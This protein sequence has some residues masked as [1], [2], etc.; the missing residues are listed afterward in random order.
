[1][2][3]YVKELKMKNHLLAVAFTSLLVPGIAFSDTIFG[4]YAGG[5][6]WSTDVDGDFTFVGVGG[7]DEIDI[8]DDLDLDGDSNT[9]LYVAVEHP[10]PFVPNIKLQRSEMSSESSTSLST[11]IAFDDVVF[12][13][14]E[15]VNSTIDLSHTDATLYYEILDNWVSLD[16]G[17]TVR[18]FDGEIDISSETNPALS[19]TVDINAPIPMLY[20]KARF[21]LPF[22]GF[23]VA[24]EINTLGF[25]SDLTIK[26]AYE[27]PFRFGVE[28]GYRTFN[29]SLDD[30][31]DL[32]TSLDIDGIFMG[33]TLHI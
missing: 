24:A 16:V 19:D 27:S 28:A 4:V 25:V 23:S 30:I 3:Q 17:M 31:D 15:A 1:M 14:N 22:S 7:N 21:D 13:V 33:L 11:S 10:L 18:L 32:D 2:Y 8:S 26:A 6:V 5:G 12:P 29:V 20:G 9:V